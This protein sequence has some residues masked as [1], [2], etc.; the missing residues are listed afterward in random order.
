MPWAAE[1]SIED[2]RTY[3]AGA[4]AQRARNDGFGALVV[5]GETII[6]SM[7]FHRI[8]WANR[9]TSLGYWL[10][11][12]RQGAGIMTA[13]VR[14]LVCH[15][16][17]AW[18]LHRVEIDAAVANVRSRAIPERLGFVEEGVRRDGE[19]FG[20]RYVDLVVYSMLA[21]DWR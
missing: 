19:R 16:F 1:P 2:T 13:A 18:E 9:A 17:T 4:L 14:A 15:A 12:D 11:A 20:D 6:G 7:G 8:D 21:P 10:S 5:D 3:L